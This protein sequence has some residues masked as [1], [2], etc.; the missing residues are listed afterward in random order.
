MKKIKQN[1][2]LSL[3][4]TLVLAG[5][6]GAI[7]QTTAPGD[8]SAQAPTAQ[9][10]GDATANAD[11]AQPTAAPAPEP[12]AATP[13]ATPDAAKA[14]STSPFDVMPNAYFKHPLF[15]LLVLIILVALIWVLLRRRV[16]K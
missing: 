7:A 10:A 11:T 4:L 15:M 5:P 2:G 14:E 16:K 1:S 9:P 12:Q 6:I 13:E 3:L 8:D